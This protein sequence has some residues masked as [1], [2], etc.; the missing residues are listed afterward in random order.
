[1]YEEL[2]RKAY[3][4]DGDKKRNKAIAAGRAI[5]NG[6]KKEYSKGGTTHCRF[7]A[8]QYEAFFSEEKLGHRLQII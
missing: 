5:D 7:D 2:A 6:L 8:V 3:A 4:N 1:M